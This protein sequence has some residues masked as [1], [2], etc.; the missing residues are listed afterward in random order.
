MPYPFKLSLLTTLTREECIRIMEYM[1]GE[2]WN[3]GEDV[4][5]EAFL[6]KVKRLTPKD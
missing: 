2:Y 6:V 1:G 4:I 5:Y 3:V